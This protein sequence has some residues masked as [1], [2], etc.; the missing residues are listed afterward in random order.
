MH[1]LM[2]EDYEPI[3]KWLRALLESI[4]GVGSIDS[5]A[6]LAEA[7]HSAT[8]WPPALA[9]LDLHLPDGN[10]THIMAA[11]QRLSPEI[12]IVVLSNDAN[13]FNRLLCRRAGAHGFFDKSTE[14]D[15]LLQFVRAHAASMPPVGGAK[16]RSILDPEATTR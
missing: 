6:T 7:L 11:L 2:V 3:R 12:K 9:V 4:P 13:E 8:Q 15:A 1:L 14:L 16:R 5:A 10:A